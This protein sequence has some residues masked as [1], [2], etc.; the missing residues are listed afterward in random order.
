M[1]DSGEPSAQNGPNEAQYGRNEAAAVGIAHNALCN[2]TDDG[3]HGHE[4]QQMKQGHRGRPIVLRRGS[5]IEY[6]SVRG[7]F[8][9]WAVRWLVA[10]NNQTAVAIP[11]VGLFG[12]RRP[13][14][15]RRVGQH[16]TNRQTETDP[17]LSRRAAPTIARPTGVLSLARPVV[18][19][20]RWHAR[21]R[22]ET[23]TWHWTGRVRD[24]A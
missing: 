3:R 18:M 8:N 10:S 22:G 13:V 7:P 17:N 20:E 6:R 9:A 23:S 2:A 14:G 5:M 16:R 11:P 15:P 4:N 1:Q 12:S 19:R 21:Q 24:D